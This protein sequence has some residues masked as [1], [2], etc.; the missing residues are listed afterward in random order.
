MKRDRQ[1]VNQRQLEVLSLIRQRQEI[2][3]S[4]LCQIFNVSPMTIRRDIQFLE[5]QGK[6]SRFHG[7]A[8]IDLETMVSKDRVDVSLC[9]GWIA[10]YA[11][12]LVQDGDCLLING[13]NTAL[14]ML[15]YLEG[16]HV[17]VYTNN[18]LAVGRN[19]PEGVDVCLLGGVLRADHILTGDLTLRNLMDIHADKAFLGCVGISP[20]GEI[21]CGIPSELSVNE[22]MI[23]HSEKY[24]I[25]ADHTKIGRSSPYAS[26][27]LEKKGC[28]ITDGFAAVEVTDR[29]QD[30]DM[31][32]VRVNDTYL[33]SGNS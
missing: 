4:E 12:G 11:A 20:S 1:S 8:T 27:L 9:R 32:V 33:N 13:S 29:L 6:I 21:L 7:G 3:V 17:I 24:F 22:T 2:L 5:K 16:K 30:G 23:S 10:Q 15:D 28:V 31:E 18:G 19:Y 26:F 14:A 25:M